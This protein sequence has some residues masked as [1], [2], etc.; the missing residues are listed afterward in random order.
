MRPTKVADILLC[1]K[2]LKETI[3][4]ITT[5]CAKRSLHKSSGET[6]HK[7]W[8]VLKH[9]HS[10][11]LTKGGKNYA[12]LLLNISDK[13]H[14]KFEPHKHIWDNANFKV[15]VDQSANY[16]SKRRALHTADIISGDLDSIDAKLIQ[17]IHNPRRPIKEA[18][19]QHNEGPGPST[20]VEM[21]PVIETPSQKETDFTKAIRVVD[22]IKP[23]MK[24]FF[25][26]YHSDGTRLDHIFGLVNTLHLFKTHAIFLLN[27]QSNTVSWLLSPGHHTILKPPGQENCSIVPFTGQAEVRTQGLLYNLHT[28]L[29][30][31]FSGLISTSNSFSKERDKIFIETNKEI[32]FSIDLANSEPATANKPA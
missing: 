26:I 13:S 5:N 30:L 16:L 25:A 23:D 21:P 22:S 9:L 19:K 4:P 28:H 7:S 6:N 2:R 11:D 1:H 15:A 12:C 8:S 20:T 27:T 18:G 14:E 3:S 31:N 32:L 10:K 29:P 17:R 24:F